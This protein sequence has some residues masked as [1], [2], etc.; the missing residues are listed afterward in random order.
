MLVDLVWY[1]T[2]LQRFTC[3]LEFQGSIIYSFQRLESLE[4]F[5]NNE[6]DILVATDL[7]AR[8]LDIPHVKTVRFFNRSYFRL[9]TVC[10]HKNNSNKFFPPQRF[11]YRVSTAIFSKNDYFTRGFN[12]GHSWTH[13]ILCMFRGTDC[14]LYPLYIYNFQVI[15]FNLPTTIKSYIHRVGRTARA[16]KAG[17]YDL[18]V[19]HCVIHLFLESNFLIVTKSVLNY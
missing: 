11:I 14:P 19:L 8:G 2:G 6:I 10:L 16:G 15:S 3:Y 7:A 13:I 17:R 4:K 9:E 18:F 12:Q 1:A 5:K